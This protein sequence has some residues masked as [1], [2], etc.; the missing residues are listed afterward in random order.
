MRLH[1][2]IPVPIALH[3]HVVVQKPDHDVVHSTMDLADGDT[4]IR[5]MDHVHDE[6]ILVDPVTI[7][8]DEQRVI[9]WRE[10]CT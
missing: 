5:S 8:E 1:T 4:V 7:L 10:L 3:Q 6:I 2:I 9:W